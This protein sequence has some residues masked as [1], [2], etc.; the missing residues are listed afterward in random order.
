L[1]PL[2]LKKRHLARRVAAV[3]KEVRMSKRQ[4]I[5]SLATV[6]TLAAVTAGVAIWIFPLESSAQSSGSDQSVGITVDTQGRKLLHGSRVDYPQS[7]REK[8]IEGTVALQLSL[9]A[10][11]EVTD[12]RVESGPEELRNSALKSA[13]QWHFANESG[14]PATIQASV[15]FKNPTSAT[16]AK[17]RVPELTR[18]TE[19]RR[20]TTTNLPDSMIQ[21][22]KS[23]L[24]I[25]EGDQLT[26]ESVTRAIET[27]H[28]IDAH[29]FLGLVAD[30]KDGSTTAIISLP[31][32]L[33]SGDSGTFNPP[34]TEGVKRLRIGGNVQSAKIISKVTP[35]YPPLA[36]QARVQGTVRYNVLISK[37]GS[38]RQMELVNGHPLLVEAATPAVQ[39]WQY[40]PTLL[41]GEP[42]EVI[43]A[44]D[45]N[46]TLAQ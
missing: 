43:T 44:I 25:R 8:Q 37:E 7:A 30:P 35:K 42:V 21:E 45:V 29:L 16:G 1:A 15:N 27:L 36:K 5:S 18:P 3:M 9:D 38:I 34:P 22:V 41:N 26:S 24:P 20:V 13:L 6:S 4:I 46:F 32:A 11:G 12:A 28:E 17:L 40:S 19:L 33:T 10:K 23:R 39:Q 2:F 31:M 14:Q